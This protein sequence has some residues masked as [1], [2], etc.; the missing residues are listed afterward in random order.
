MTSEKI[1]VGEKIREVSSVD[2]FPL[3]FGENDTI[4]VTYKEGGLFY[5]AV[6]ILL[7]GDGGVAYQAVAEYQSP[8]VSTNLDNYDRIYA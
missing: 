3:A 2:R 6:A 8:I 4:L 7:G 5:Q 1:K